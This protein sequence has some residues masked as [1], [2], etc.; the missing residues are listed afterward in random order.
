MYSH[1]VPPELQVRKLFALESMHDLR[2]SP[3]EQSIC[4]AEGV[5]LRPDYPRIPEVDYFRRG[6]RSEELFFVHTRDGVQEQVQTFLRSLA[7]L[8]TSR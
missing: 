4:H 6:V 7:E 2:L 5:V 8:E 1:P 3:D